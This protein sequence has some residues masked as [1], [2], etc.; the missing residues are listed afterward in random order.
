[1]IGEK[2]RP[3]GKFEWVLSK[4]PKEKW[5]FIGCL[6]TEDRFIASVRMLEK[7]NLLNR[8]LFF[9]I[10]DP[11]SQDSEIISRI[12]S[13]NEK[14]LH[15]EVKSSTV[16]EHQLLEANV[17]IVNSIKTFLQ[18]TNSNIIVDISTFPKRFFFPIVK[19]LIENNPKN[20]IIT[21]ST[22]DKY[23]SEDLASNPD[24][25]QHLPLF[26][27]VDFPE[28]QIDLAIVGIG[29]MPFSLPNLLMSKYKSIPVKFLFPFPPGPPN[30][31]RTWEFVRKIEKSFTFNHQ[32]SIIR[33]DSTN[34][35]DA[36]EYITRE[37]NNGQKNVI[38]APYGPKPIS[39]AMCIY[40]ILYKSAVY[41]TQPTHYN[42]IYSSGIKNT[43]AYCISLNSKNLYLNSATIIDNS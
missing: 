39:L 17:K 33:I 43:F 42:P 13:I 23:S 36:F 28:P 1:M 29:F 10:I 25:W 34:L 37:T 7:A 5:D 30:Y 3:W 4:I 14:K 24:S 16:V 22:P 20:L 6:S 35:P 19:L 40:A 8:S 21:Y 32:D 9:K 2:F 15:K 26:M 27:P 41:Y 38:F 12:L 18:N 31:Q 11:P